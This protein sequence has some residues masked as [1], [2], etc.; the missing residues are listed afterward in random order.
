MRRKTKSQITK[1]T[2]I[3]VAA[4]MPPIS[5]QLTAGAGTGV[6]AGA[7]VG[8]GAGAGVGGGAGAGAGAGGGAGLTVNVPDRPLTFTV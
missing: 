2:T 5:H 6:G 3:A 4:A 8:S 7:G 1:L